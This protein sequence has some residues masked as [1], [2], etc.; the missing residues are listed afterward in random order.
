MTTKTAKRPASSA[1][2]F[3]AKKKAAPVKTARKVA[4]KAAKK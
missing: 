1:K 3:K 4:R 2:L